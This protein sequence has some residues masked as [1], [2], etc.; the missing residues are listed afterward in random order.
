MAETDVAGIM[1]KFRSEFNTAYDNKKT[2]TPALIAERFQ[3]IYTLISA[4]VP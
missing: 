1:T 4:C 3:G 2:A